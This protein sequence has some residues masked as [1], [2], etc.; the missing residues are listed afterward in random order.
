MADKLVGFRDKRIET[1]KGAASFEQYGGLL[2]IHL[3]PYESERPDSIFDLRKISPENFLPPGR[4]Y[5][6]HSIIRINFDGRMTDFTI[7][8]ERRTYVQVYR[9]GKVEEVD[10]L[11]LNNED[12]YSKKYIDAT[13]LER[14]IIKGVGARLALLQEIGVTSPVM[15]HISL[16]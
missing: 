7:A 5:D 13:E 8:D 3:Q 1:I 15:L 9:S 16:L 4:E 2:V 11:V 6:D 10:S 12:R 14:G